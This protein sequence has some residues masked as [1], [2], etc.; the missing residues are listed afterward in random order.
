MI[1]ISGEL[2][3]RQRVAL[4]PGGT[5]TVTLRDVSRQ[6]TVAP[7]VA[8]TEIELGDHQVPIPFEL[9][10]DESDVARRATYAVR[11]TITGPGGE[12]RWTTDTAEPVDLTQSAIDLGPLMLVQVAHDSDS[13]PS[14]S[15][16]PSAAPPS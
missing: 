4:V 13:S 15:S 8:D 16:T 1:T 12:L 11:A 9:T 6:D 14:C 5:A 2:T 7:I 3:Y 10:V